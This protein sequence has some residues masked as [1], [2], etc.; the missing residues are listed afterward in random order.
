MR[1]RIFFGFVIMLLCTFLGFAQRASDQYPVR[2]GLY[3][4][5]LNT[6][7]PAHIGTDSRASITAGY[8]GYSGLRKNIRTFY[9]V[10]YSQLSAKKEKP[11]KHYVGLTMYSDREGDFIRRSRAYLNYNLRLPVSDQWDVAAGGSFGAVNYAVASS[12]YR[13]GGSSFVFDGNAGIQ[14]SDPKNSFGVAINQLFDQ[15]L[16][17]LRYQVALQRHFNFYYSR[18]IGVSE[19]LELHGV[20]WVRWVEG[21]PLVGLSGVLEFKEKLQFGLNYG[22]NA[23]MTTS[24]GVENVSLEKNGLFDFVLGFHFPIG[25]QGRL[26]SQQYEIGLYYHIKIKVDE[27]VTN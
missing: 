20:P 1:R 2:F 9:I 21:N 11:I 8:Q 18:I 19:N 14:L 4:F 22:H 7:N 17:P 6:I 26:N 23:T 15:V 24:L 25:N 5:A 13:S 3:E 27:V 10:G 12:Q 16:Q